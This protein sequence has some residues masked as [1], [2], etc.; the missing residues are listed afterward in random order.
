MDYPVRKSP[1][2]KCFDYSTPTSYFITIC[3]HEKKCLFGSITQP[4]EN[5]QIA[6]K[7]IDQ[8]PVHFPGIKINHSVVMPNHVHLLLTVYFDQIP[9]GMDFPDIINVIGTYKAAVSRQIHQTHPDI[10]IWQRSFHDH[11]IRTEGAWQKI[12]K[13]ID[14][15]PYHWDEDCYHMNL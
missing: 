13:Y 12:W 5:A 6:K 7:A 9:I 3:T 11:V 10:L 15:N 4:N 2:M 1:R 14:E 8:I